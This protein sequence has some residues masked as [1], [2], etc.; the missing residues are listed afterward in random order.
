MEMSIRHNCANFFAIPSKGTDETLLAKYLK[1][2]RKHSFDGGRHQIRI[3][4]LESEV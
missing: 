1:L 3:Q 4:E 2:A